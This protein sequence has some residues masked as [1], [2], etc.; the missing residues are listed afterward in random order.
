MLHTGPKA[1]PGVLFCPGASFQLGL[2][3][4]EEVAVLGLLAKAKKTPIP[5]PPWNLPVQKALPLP[6]QMFE[7]LKVRGGET[8]IC[9]S[10]TLPGRGANHPP[11]GP[12]K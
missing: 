2:G 12:S 4:G 10:L 6:P 11:P 7:D 8:L 1:E 9:M 3:G 5:A